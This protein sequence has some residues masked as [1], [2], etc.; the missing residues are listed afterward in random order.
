MFAYYFPHNDVFTHQWLHCVLWLYSDFNPRV[1]A[2]VCSS[3]SNYSPQR[4]NFKFLDITN[5]SAYFKGT[6]PRLE[7]GISDLKPSNKLGGVQ[8][9]VAWDDLTAAA[10]ESLN[11]VNYGY[12]TTQQVPLNDANFRVFMASAYVRPVEVQ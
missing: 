12:R 11:K 9:M 7:K 6:R 3:P 10:K 5:N 1:Y 4:L 2:I 8:P